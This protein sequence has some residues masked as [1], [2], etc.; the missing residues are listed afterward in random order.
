MPSFACETPRST[1]GK[2]KAWKIASIHPILQAYNRITRPSAL[3]VHNSRLLILNQEAGRNSPL[4]SS[5]CRPV[6]IATSVQSALK[7]STD[8]DPEDER[9]GEVDEVCESGVDELHSLE[10][11]DC[12]DEAEKE[13]PHCGDTCTEVAENRSA[14]SVVSREA[15]ERKEMKTSGGLTSSEQGKSNGTPQGTTVITAIASFA[16]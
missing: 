9:D 8:C 14:F 1:Q 3:R 2:V 4:S 12:E 7:R 5:D 10:G 16:N 11:A 6:I 15:R 13:R